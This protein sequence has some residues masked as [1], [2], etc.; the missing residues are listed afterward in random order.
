MKGLSSTS[1]IL[2]ELIQ[3]RDEKL[4][5]DEF[6]NNLSPYYSAK[7]K[8]VLLQILQETYFLSQLSMSE[9]KFRFSQPQLDLILDILRNEKILFKKGGNWV[10]RE[11]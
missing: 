11:K 2:K 9:L 7:R 1:R 10:V 6:R 4:L 3:G 5:L 8:Y